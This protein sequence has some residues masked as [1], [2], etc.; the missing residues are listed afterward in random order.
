[1][2]QLKQWWEGLEV[3]EQRL[4]LISLVVVGVGILYFAV[5]QPL[6]NELTTTQDKVRKAKQTLV[7]VKD[8][9]QQIITIKGGGGQVTLGDQNLNRLVSST[10]Q[11]KN[12]AISR[13]QQNKED[14]QVWIDKVEFSKL[15]SWL[16]ELKSSHGIS[17]LN[18][19]LVAGDKKGLVRV[20]RLQLGSL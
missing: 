6:Q 9:G 18:A 3:R 4:V 5:W 8:N 13:I 12:I 20:R 17:V 11:Q 7:W 14:V 1:M 10:A 2:N 15:I 16:G 19:D